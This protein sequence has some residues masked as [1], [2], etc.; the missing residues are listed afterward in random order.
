MKWKDAFKIVSTII[1]LL[2]G[3]YVLNN[4]IG[5]IVD[6]KINNPEFI[7]EIS[8]KARRPIVIFNQNESI[9][10]DI[11]AMKYTDKIK[12][13][14]NKED[15]DVEKIIVSPKSH[16]KAAPLLESLDAAYTQIVERGKKFE[17]IYKLDSIDRLLLAGSAKPAEE[18]RFRLEIVY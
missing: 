3:L 16:L 2:G 17:W 9:L 8:E 7:N 15:K 14:F 11:G 1:F 6:Q 4:H 10:I 13:I 18:Q 5:D 12:V